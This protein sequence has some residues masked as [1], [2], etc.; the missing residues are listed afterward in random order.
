MDF[1]G[2]L[3]FH[4]GQHGVTKEVLGRPSG[5]VTGGAAASHVIAAAVKDVVSVHQGHDPR[6]FVETPA[7][8]R[9][10]WSLYDRLEYADETM[11]G[12]GHYDETYLCE[13]GQWRFTSL[14]LTRLR[15]VW[16]RNR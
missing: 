13:Q 9:G 16:T 12:Y 2:E 15:V 14:L 3:E 1:S 8:A 11:H 10:R 5:K 7:T 6:I 4:V